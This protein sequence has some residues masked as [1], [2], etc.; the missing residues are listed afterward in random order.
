MLSLR[1]DAVTRF[2][3]GLLLVTV[4]IL[5]CLLVMN[6]SGAATPTTS[7]RLEPSFTR[8]SIPF[9]IKVEINKMSQGSGEQPNLV[10]ETNIPPA[11]EP[12]VLQPTTTWNSAPIQ[13]ACRIVA[14]LIGVLGLIY[15]LIRVK[16]SGFSE[17]I[18]P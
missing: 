14:A 10:T 9:E 2:V 7:W 17:E 4:G 12:A 18:F 5:A 13:G 8:D 16:Q 15:L 11:P 6:F 1:L 3:G